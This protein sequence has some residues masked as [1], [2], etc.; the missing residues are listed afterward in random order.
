M[1]ILDLFRN[2]ACY[3][4]I[5]VHGVTSSAMVLVE[6]ILWKDVERVVEGVRKRAMRTGRLIAKI[7]GDNPTDEELEEAIFG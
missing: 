4:L 1:T 7:W 2:V 6:C 3:A 5:F